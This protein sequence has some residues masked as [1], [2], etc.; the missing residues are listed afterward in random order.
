MPLISPLVSALTWQEAASDA[1]LLDAWRALAT[2]APAENALHSAPEWVEHY[3]G[4]SAPGVAVLVARTPGGAIA[5]V[6]PTVRLSFVLGRGR[7]SGGLPLSKLTVAC[8]LGSAPLLDGGVPVADVIEG[9]LASLP[10]CDALYFDSLPAD[11]PCAAL[12]APG[13][14]AGRFLPHRL[15]TGRLHS[16]VLGSS[17]DDYLA[18]RPARSRFKLKRAARLLEA[19]GTLELVRCDAPEGLDDFLREAVTV[20]ERS[21]HAKSG[22][23]LGGNHARYRREL[24]DLAQRGWLRCYLLRCGDSACAFAIGYQAHGVY[25]Y[26]EIAHDE[27]FAALSPGTVLFLRL[28]EDLHSVERP[29]ILDFGV[30]DDGYK[31]R[32]GTRARPVVSG[33]LFRPARRNRLRIGAHR[34][35]EGAKGLAFAVRQ[36]G[37]RP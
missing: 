13:A 29:A 18:Q 21:W 36:R 20:Y 9:A 3:A 19:R 24:F 5:G 12:F 33:L 34:L 6:V 17:Y 28:L 26:Q 16:L 30:G 2:R 1:G 32:F 15:S 8:V 35:I 37:R 27:A 14:T 25:H 10:D 23:E 11:N 7:R 4:K 31:R 22:A